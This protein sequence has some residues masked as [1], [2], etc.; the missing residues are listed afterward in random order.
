MKRIVLLAM[1]VLAGCGADR[2]PPA[3]RNADTGAQATR[4][5]TAAWT[6]TPR[7]DVLLRDEAGELVIITGPHAVLWMPDAAP[8]E[9]PYTLRAVLQKRVGRIHEGFGVVFGGESLDA[10]EEQQLYSYFLIRGDG[11]FLIRRR[12][13][14]ALLILRGWTTNR[15]IRRDRDG[16][17]QPNELRVEVGVETTIFRVNGTELAQ[18]PTADLQVVGVPGLRVAHNIELVVRE[19]TADRGAAAQR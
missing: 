8:L 15:A 6:S 13:G 3:A 5:V 1:L 18:L 16:V 19:F 9:P 10:P 17:G 2:S 4:P 12:E 14:A 7:D 11:S